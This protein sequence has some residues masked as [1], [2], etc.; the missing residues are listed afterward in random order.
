MASKVDSSH[1][2]PSQIKRCLSSSKYIQLATCFHDQPH[3][4]L[5]TFTYLPAGSAAPYEVEDCIILSTGENSKK[6][7]NIS[8]NPRVSLLV[9]DWTTNRQET[10]PDA[11]SLCTLLYKM[12]QAQFSNTSVTLNGLATVLPKNSKEEEFF[13][14]KHLNTND[15]GNTKQYVEG[16][17]MRIIKIKLESARICDQ[18]LNNV[19]KWNAR[20]DE[21]P[22]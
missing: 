18:R 7:F 22:F 11:S 5:M 14:E 4:S 8:S 9:H 17:D 1:E 10:D 21:T 3:S 20:G 13:R 19:Q 12:N 15:K 2:F 6:Y 16:E